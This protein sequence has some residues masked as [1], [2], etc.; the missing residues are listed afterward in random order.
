M[1]VFL[2]SQH[3]YHGRTLLSQRL[4]Q[5]RNLALTIGSRCVIYLYLDVER[6]RRLQ[7]GPCAALLRFASRLDMSIEHV[8]PRYRRDQVDPV[9]ISRVRHAHA[10]RPVD[11]PFLFISADHGFVPTIRQIAQQRRPIYIG[12]PCTTD[13]PRL[14]Y[15][16]TGWRYVHPEAWFYIGLFATL[17]TDQR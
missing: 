6:F 4:L 5:I 3:V 7:P 9:M 17:N 11:E 10:T 16:G 14:A 8:A 15:S 12:L 1:N 2:D 13:I